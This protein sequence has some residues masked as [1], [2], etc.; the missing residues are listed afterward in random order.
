[1]QGQCTYIKHLSAF[2]DFQKFSHNLYWRTDGTFASDMSAFYQQAT[3]VDSGVPNPPCTHDPTLNPNSL[4][5]GLWQFYSFSDWQG[6]GEDAGSVVRNPHF[7]FPYFPFDDF[8]MPFGSPLPGFVPF[9][10]NEAGRKFPASDAP[11]VAPTFMTA[12]F[13]PRTD[14]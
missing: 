1:V 14:F 10:P 4:N 13:N 12:P 3:P 9:N 6:L 8:W 5:P 7:L 2:T 11:P